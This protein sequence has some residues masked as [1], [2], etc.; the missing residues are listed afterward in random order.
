MQHQDHVSFLCCIDPNGAARSGASLIRPL[1]KAR[2]QHEG[3]VSVLCSIDLNGAA[4]SA[5]ILPRPSDTAGIQH[6]R[7]CFSAASIS[8]LL[9]IWPLFCQAVQH[10]RDT[11]PRHVLFLCCVVLIAT[12]KSVTNLIAV[13]RHGRDTAEASHCIRVSILARVR[14]LLK[15]LP[16]VIESERQAADRYGGC[17]KIEAD[18]ML[19]LSRDV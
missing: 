2:M 14:D 16:T 10:R 18:N 9:Q 6:L 15:R 5:T 12:A 17:A 13:I 4:R 19:Q 11:T 7:M 1:N 8:K 3:N